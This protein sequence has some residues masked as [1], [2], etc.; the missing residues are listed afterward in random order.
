MLAKGDL[1]YVSDM[2]SWFYEECDETAQKALSNQL[3]S[4]A[5]KCF[6]D[7]SRVSY[8]AWRDIPSWYMH[9]TKDNAVPYDIQKVFVSH[10]GGKWTT[11]V[12]DGDHSPM[13][14]RVDETV[15]IIREAA[16]HTE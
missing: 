16:G 14:S 4:H 12:C 9:N 2:V 15:S 7:C 13:I 6:M 5:W 8:T 11:K 10:E 3:Q 1:C